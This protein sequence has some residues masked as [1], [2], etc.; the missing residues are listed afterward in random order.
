MMDSSASV[1]A[2]NFAM[3]KEFTQKLTNRFLGA[4]RQPNAQVRVAVGQYSNAA[5]MEADF[6]NNATE[7]T[8]KIAEAKFQNLGTQVTEA[9]NFAIS[10][11]RGGRARAKKLLLFSDGRSQGINNIQIEKAVEQVENNRIELYVL[12][13]ANEL[14][15][16]NLRILVS[17]GRPYDN[18]YAYRHL[19]KAP[20][21]R[22]LLR[23]VFYQ[24]VSRKISLV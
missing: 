1:G 3:T 7:V 13:V 15:E 2:K 20:D 17:R 19:F 6:S 18:N 24:T 9:L 5:Q 8:A 22:A 11:F 10:R 12:A 4:E 16:A 14:N 23:G 21:Y